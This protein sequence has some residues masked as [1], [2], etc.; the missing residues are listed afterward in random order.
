MND[1]LS[2]IEEIQS[3]VRELKSTWGNTITMLDNIK[4]SLK[5]DSQKAK[6][7]AY[8]KGYEMGEQVGAANASAMDYQKGF[9]DG[10]REGLTAIP[11]NT[12]KYNYD[13]T[14]ICKTCRY[15]RASQYE[16]KVRKNEDA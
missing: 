3:D 8:A 10:K 12:C 16:Q 2:Q 14:G 15:G 6:E 1:I 7:D 11:C 9:E 4:T 5:A 13:G